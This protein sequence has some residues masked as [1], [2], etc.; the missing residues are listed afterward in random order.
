MNATT[1][2]GLREG[3]GRPH[4]HIENVLV[5]VL[6]FDGDKDVLL[7]GPA[8]TRKGE[9]N[10]ASMQRA[11]KIAAH[12]VGEQAQSVKIVKRFCCSHGDSEVVQ[13]VHPCQKM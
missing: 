7:A 3:A 2:G 6:D 12:H 11:K 9:P 4:A 10:Q 5:E 8:L 13:V 1:W